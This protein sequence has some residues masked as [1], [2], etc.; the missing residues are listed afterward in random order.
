MSD[1]DPQSPPQKTAIRLAACAKTFADGT[2]ALEPMSLEI[3][4]GETIVFLGPSGCGKT[5]TLRIIAGLE[6]PDSGGKI[7]FGSEDVTDL[8]IE[9]RNVGMV[10]QSYAL[11]PNMSVEQN[12]AYGLKIRKIAK[13]DIADRVEQML[14]MMHIEE[15]RNRT[16]DQLSGGQRQRVALA[17][18]IAVRPKVLLLDEP[19][20]ALDALLRERLRVDID[21]LLRSLGITTVYVTHDQAEA[22]SLG[23]RIVV[24]DRGRAAQIGTPREIYFKPQEAFVADFIGTMNRI[25]G[26]VN[27]GKFSANGGSIKWDADQSGAVDLLFRPENAVI[28]DKA[29]AVFSGTVAT[30]FFLGDR[31]RIIIDGIGN[32]QV[33]LETDNRATL[34]QGDAVSIA[35]DPEHLVS[36]KQ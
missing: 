11:F 29:S 4:G 26:V 30:S 9:E 8:P 22:M 13:K 10:F 24:M 16:I 36:I 2:R 28:T 32:E 15:L 20:T 7:F 17:R 33:T 12:I 21:Q 25:S 18:A 19:L 35:I 23:D 1:I 27:N 34:K 5:T 31:M 3:K 14:A 6:S